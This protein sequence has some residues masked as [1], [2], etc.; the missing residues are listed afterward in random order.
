MKIFGKTLKEYI[1]PI[2]Y[3][4][5]ASVLIVIAQY[6]L[7]L[8]MANQYPFILNVTQALWAIMVVL[9]VIKL[10]VYYGFNFKNII[11]LGVMYSFI[12]HGLKAF[13]FR[14]FLFPY[15]DQT[16]EQYVS[17]LL[18]RFFYGSFLVMIIVII[19]GP[20]F[21]KLKNNQDVRKTFKA[22]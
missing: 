20:I 14:V 2:K 17:H 3:Y 11:F 7:A 5:I 1:L 9:S 10:A 13:V 19:L 22:I 15:L 12:I 16:V 8:P 4:V 6:Y 18:D 21:I